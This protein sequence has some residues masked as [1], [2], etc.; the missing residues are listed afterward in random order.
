MGKH[1]NLLTGA[2]KKE[3]RWGQRFQ[4]LRDKSVLFSII[5]KKRKEDILTW[6]FNWVFCS[7]VISKKLNPSETMQIN[8]QYLNAFFKSLEKQ[9]SKILQVLYYYL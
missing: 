7:N 1:Q 9:P 4:N 2:W 8:Y 3:H 6:L 5:K